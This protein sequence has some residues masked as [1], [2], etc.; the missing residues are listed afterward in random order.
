M[1][2]NEMSKVRKVVTVAS[3][4]V[5]FGALAVGVFFPA[6]PRTMIFGV[7]M[8][9]VAVEVMAYFGFRK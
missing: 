7:E 1:R 3:N 6:I 9:A 2:Y 8:A 5:F 4:V